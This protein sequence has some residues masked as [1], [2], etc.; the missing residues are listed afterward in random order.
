MQLFFAFDLHNNAKKVE[1][2]VL[3]FARQQPNVQIAQ[4]DPRTNWNIMLCLFTVNTA[5]DALT[6]RKAIDQR[7]KLVHSKYAPHMFRSRNVHAELN[8]LNLM[9]FT[10]QESK[11]FQQKAAP[12]TMRFLDV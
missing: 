12:E 10:A 11:Q 5:A 3:S 4:I 6:L 2:H 7:C 9:G 8:Q 1:Q